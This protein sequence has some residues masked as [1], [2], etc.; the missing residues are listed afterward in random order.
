MAVQNKLIESVAGVIMGVAGDFVKVKMRDSKL[1]INFPKA[2]FLDANHLQ[3]GQPVL[4]EIRERSDGYRYQSIIPV[5]DD[6]E[7]PYLSE[8]KSILDEI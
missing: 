4:Y 6:E 3:Y 8:V 2:L 7:N 5:K 1:V